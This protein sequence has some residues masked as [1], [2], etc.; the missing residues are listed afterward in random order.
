MLL[1]NEIS[2][3]FDVSPTSI[4]SFENLSQYKVSFI[5]KQL[6]TG[7]IFDLFDG[8]PERD[9]LKIFVKYIDEKVLTISKKSQEELHKFDSFMQPIKNYFDKDSDDFEI[10]IEIKKTIQDGILSI[11]N[12]HDFSE[13]V[14]KQSASDF[15][16]MFSTLKNHSNEFIIFQCL[17]DS[18]FLKTGYMRIYY[19]YSTKAECTYSNTLRDAIIEKRKVICNITS[20]DIEFIPNDFKIYEGNVPNEIQLYLNKLC[21]TLSLMY[22]ADQSKLQGNVLSFTF[23]G[24]RLVNR[25]VD[26]RNDA[27]TYSDI[28][29]NIYDWLYQ[30]GNIFDKAQIVRNVISLHCKYS[31]ILAIDEAVFHSIKSNY[32]LYLK[33]N[34]KDYLSLKKDIVN[35]LQAYCDKISESINSF[36]GSFKTNFI[37]ILGYIATILFSKGV[38][39]DTSK[40]FTPD[41][42]ILTSFVLLGSAVVFFLCRLHMH[43]QK[44][45]YDTTISALKKSYQDILEKNEINDL[46]DSNSLLE[47]ANANYRSST[48]IVSITWI[49]FIIGAFMA[50]DYLSGNVKLL[51]LINCF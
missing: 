42:A 39:K 13:K 6:V 46:I 16:Y 37:A 12:F 9:N 30:N 20:D 19:K 49:I 43:F 17:N 44:N 40:I 1:P 28:F 50:L 47:V 25:S 32:N 22:L 5:T 31:D 23:N 15:L 27:V 26:L 18:I 7:K 34:V 8:V 10:S 2:K 35:S 4:T 41:I 45:Y 38:T 29:F 11:Y 33:E 36:A 24:Y 48:R 21:F 14:F 3:Q 51:F